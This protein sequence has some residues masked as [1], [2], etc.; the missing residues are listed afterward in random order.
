VP[1]LADKDE[2][3]GIAGRALAPHF[4]KTEGEACAA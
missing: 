1:E 3:A 4:R 2:A